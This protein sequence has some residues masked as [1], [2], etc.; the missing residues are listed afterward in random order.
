METTKKTVTCNI[1]IALSIETD[2]TTTSVIYGDYQKKFTENDY[3]KE[4]GS[5]ANF[6]KMMQNIT[7]TKCAKKDDVDEFVVD[8]VY[9]SIVA[10]QFDF[11]LAK[12]KPEEITLNDVIKTFEQKLNAS[13]RD[14]TNT[15]AT[16]N[17]NSVCITKDDSFE[18]LTKSPNQN[19]NGWICTVHGRNY[20]YNDVGVFQ[21]LCKYFANLTKTFI[22]TCSALLRNHIV[23]SYFI[24]TDKHDKTKTLAEN[25][26]EFKKLDFVAILL[27]NL[28]HQT[29]I[30]Q[31]PI[32]NLFVKN[33]CCIHFTFKY[34]NVDLVELFKKLNVAKF[35][36]TVFDDLIA[37]NNE[38]LKFG[39]PYFTIN[40][41][42]KS[43]ILAN[44]D[45]KWISTVYYTK[46][47]DVKNDVSKCGFQ[48][49]H[50]HQ[51]FRQHY[52]FSL[53][54]Y[55]H[56]ECENK[57]CHISNTIKNATNAR[58]FQQHCDKIDIE[59]YLSV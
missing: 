7:V 19:I 29:F 28:I 22:H 35:V 20:Y 6:T 52:Y 59:Q 3:P 54:D 49:A 44:Y 32:V 8:C 1:P 42:Q 50:I 23:Q 53:G 16:D 2:A 12:R 33:D 40:Y 30:L 39:N 57:I 46:L 45:P 31:Y 41:K 27:N 4:A 56:G 15:F 14:V 5:F 48:F 47:S 13:F 11:I 18:P 9:D 37:P 10:F 25:I 36:E 58:I 43:A 51:I 24:S 55:L 34:A 21:K 38:L 17:R 26:A